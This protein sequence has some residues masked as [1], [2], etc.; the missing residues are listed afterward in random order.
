[1]KREVLSL[2]L[3][4]LPCIGLILPYPA[5]AIPDLPA[6]LRQADRSAPVP[7]PSGSL[8]FIVGTPDE[9]ERSEQ[10]RQLQH[11]IEASLW[12]EGAEA[13]HKILAAAPTLL[14]RSEAVHQ[15]SRLQVRQI[16]RDGPPPLR[17]AYR[18]RFLHEAERRYQAASTLPAMLETT[19]RY[20]F[21]AGGKKALDRAI[22]LLL[23]QGDLSGAR[24]LWKRLHP[25][26]PEA[27]DSPTTLFLTARLDE[28]R[29][30]AQPLP[31]RTFDPGEPI[32]T[33]PFEEVRQLPAAP[34]AFL[35]RGIPPPPLRSYLCRA[36]RLFCVSH[37]G[38]QAF[39]T[40]TGGLLWRSERLIEKDP[41]LADAASGCLQEKT[42][43]LTIGGRLLALEEETGRALWVDAHDGLQG[44]PLLF[45]S[46]PLPDGDRLFIGAL[47]RKPH[48]DA[49]SHLCCIDAATGRLRW[50]S[51]ITASYHTE[52]LSIG[53]RPSPPLLG[54]GTLFY[55]DPLGGI[56]AVAP[57]DGRPLWLFRH[58]PLGQRK[59]R[60]LRQEGDRWH[61]APLFLSDGRLLAAPKDADL[62]WALDAATGEPIWESDRRSQQALFMEEGT[63]ITH[64][65]DRIQTRRMEDGS[66]SWDAPLPAPAIGIGV[67][68]GMETLI[69]TEE[70]LV[71]ADADRRLLKT[72]YR[73]PGAP[74]VRALTTATPDFLFID[75]WG[76]LTALEPY[77]HSLR[78]YRSPETKRTQETLLHQ[79]ALA[80]LHG[81]LAQAQALLGAA[82]RD[83]QQTEAAHRL[84]FQA[85][86]VHA[87]QRHAEHRWDEALP[88]YD[89]LHPWAQ[90]DA[91]RG[92]LLLRQAEIA[93]ALGDSKTGLVYWQKLGSP[94]FQKISLRECLE[95]APGKDEDPRRL[96]P[97]P[98][99]SYARWRVGRIPLP[100]EAEAQRPPPSPGAAE[101]SLPSSWKPIRYWSTG[102]RPGADKR[103]VPTVPSG[104]PTS[105]LLLYEADHLECIDLA[106]GQL[107]WLKPI[108][109]LP[110]E[111]LRFEE[112]WFLYNDLEILCLGSEGHPQWLLSLHPT[113]VPLSGPPVVH[114][115]DTGRPLLLTP[116]SAAGA[117][118]ILI[119][120]LL[121]SRGRLLVQLGDG[122]ILALDPASGRLLWERPLDRLLPKEGVIVHDEQGYLYHPPSGRLKV[123]SL[124][125]GHSIEEKTAQANGVYLIPMPENRLLLQSGKRIDAYRTPSLEPIWTAPLPEPELWSRHLWPTPDAK[126]LLVLCHP[127]EGTTPLVCLDAGTGEPLWTAR[128]EGYFS[129]EDILCAPEGIYLLDREEPAL[130]VYDADA[131]GQPRGKHPLPLKYAGPWLLGKSH[132]FVADL[133]G[134]RCAAFSRE[135]GSVQPLS[136][137][138]GSMAQGLVSGAEGLGVVS[139]RGVT[140]LGPSPSDERTFELLELLELDRPEKEW[141]RVLRL[142]ELAAG[143]DG[144][145]W[146]QDRLSESLERADRRPERA[147]LNDGRRSLQELCAFSA[148]P[149]ARALPRSTPLQVD[150]E[151]NDPLAEFARVDLIGRRWIRPWDPGEAGWAGP[152]DLSARLYL[153]WNPDYLYVVLDVLDD[154]P[155]TFDQE[156][157]YDRGD[158]LWL[159][160]DGLGDG[161][162]RLNPADDRVVGLAVQNPPQNPPP[163]EELPPG[164]YAAK[165]GT[166]DG[167]L[168]YEAA[169]PW[170]YL[171]R[172]PPP[173]GPPSIGFDLL[174]LDDDGEGVRQ[175][176]SWSAGVPLKQI[177]GGEGSASFAPQLFGKVTLE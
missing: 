152:D 175:S 64:G 120:Q 138:L 93:E 159:V 134:G 154:I 11:L 94:P 48:G 35:E 118:G 83:P 8:P 59:L 21:T 96:L 141:S 147:L 119:Q 135:E 86:L 46:P 176:L 72:I 16:L 162:Y 34:D 33:F 27:A 109:A 56:A 91:Q 6:P 165:R 166:D 148:P 169:I 127:Q 10:L 105:C 151:L 41:F 66:L 53:I 131:H 32:W 31:P 49:E 4:L 17:E 78:R 1:M 65:R 122:R 142:A 75:T 67:C 92:Y 143:W 112:R 139:E 174:L 157:G 60:R 44:E 160:F 25:G 104:D 95:V 58:P 155:V 5:W 54:E 137:F 55:A 18:E 103:I 40:K 57:T 106:R 99:A 102:D 150:G 43:Y 163:P 117:T 84:L 121:A 156:L 14:P 7:P 149:T 87:E 20:P 37:A 116:P 126:K 164:Q 24:S 9:E 145:E 2:R 100:P 51:P 144:Y 101:T 123:L 132:L 146:A 171:G 69:P 115:P 161:G 177:R 63:I 61:Q 85:F 88:L 71:V 70:G 81:D 172:P 74:P 133:E 170:V 128:P 38:V 153:T 12:K 15:D 90:T 136:P 168:V 30:P 89:E 52:H 28:R 73:W 50:K 107:S 45:C 77:A 36:G 130:L 79:G 98:L 13:A 29:S 124:E 111:A 3:L 23:E 80:A 42:L 158:S 167:H 125:D 173:E 19:E 97:I 68:Q 129:E 82:A 39:E 26:H 76:R 114:G 62:L 47:R 22:F 113:Q 110:R 140:L 108:G